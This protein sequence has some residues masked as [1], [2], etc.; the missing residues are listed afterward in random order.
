MQEVVE[1][2]ILDLGF[3]DPVKMTTFE[4]HMAFLCEDVYPGLDGNSVA[5]MSILLDNDTVA[6]LKFSDEGNKSVYEDAVTFKGTIDD[7][8]NSLR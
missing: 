2:A 4:G 1:D 6:V 5:I 3:S 8:I 7:I